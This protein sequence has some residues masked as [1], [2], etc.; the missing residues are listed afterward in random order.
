MMRHILYS[1]CIETLS[2]SFLYQCSDH[3]DSRRSEPEHQLTTCASC[4][5]PLAQCLLGA[6]MA[7]ELPEVQPQ[8]PMLQLMLRLQRQREP[9]P[10]RPLN[11]PLLAP[12]PWP[13]PRAWRP[14][15]RLP[16]L[17]L[18]AR[19]PLPPLSWRP[20]LRPLQLPLLLLSPPA[21]PELACAIMRM[22]SA[23]VPGAIGCYQDPVL[24]RSVDALSERKSSL[25]TFLPRELQLPRQG[26]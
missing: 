25:R 7:S 11:L 10:W 19:R 13:Q 17:R 23:Y 15:V 18:P 1:F 22:A 9:L 26:P 3:G 2:L 24:A 8:L 6:E 12:R 4:P 21:P 16:Q 14:P 5:Q 20:T